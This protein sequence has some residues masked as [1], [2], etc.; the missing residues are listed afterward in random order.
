[1]FRIQEETTKYANKEENMTHNQQKNQSI[2]WI[3]R[4]DGISRQLSNSYYKHAQGFK[5]VSENK[6]NGTSR[7]A[8]SNY[9]ESI[10]HYK[11]KKDREI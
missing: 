2:D 8:N 9:L 4:I 3:E 6:S 10:W 1:M 11:K 7:N 5:G